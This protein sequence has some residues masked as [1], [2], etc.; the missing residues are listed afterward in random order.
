MQTMS[1]VPVSGNQ[2]D[3]LRWLDSVRTMSSKN[4]LLVY[5]CTD[6]THNNV[7]P[8]QEFFDQV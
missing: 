5:R 2:S 6:K 8:N 7:L 4:T 1:L 3:S